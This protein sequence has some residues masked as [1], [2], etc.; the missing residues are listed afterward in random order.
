[1]LSFQGVIISDIYS[2]IIARISDI[3][4]I[5]P[6]E[7]ISDISCQRYCVMESVF[8]FSDFKIFVAPG[9]NILVQPLVVQF[10]IEIMPMVKLGSEAQPRDA[11]N[12]LVLFLLDT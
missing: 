9:H 6:F 7:R 8:N 1:M 4:Y 5:V 10:I 2:A 3:S 11:S 12:Q